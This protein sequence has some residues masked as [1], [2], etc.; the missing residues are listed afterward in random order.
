MGKMNGS[1]LCEQKLADKRT[2]AKGGPT[3]SCSSSANSEDGEVDDPT[4]VSLIA[5]LTPG[6]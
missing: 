2:A 5:E 1:L 3:M 6:K 4:G